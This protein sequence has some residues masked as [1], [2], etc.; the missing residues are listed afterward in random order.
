[1]ARTK[2]V[3]SLKQLANLKNF[4]K[5]FDRDTITSATVLTL[6]NEG[7]KIITAAYEDRKW[8]NRTYNL[9]N[10]YVAAV[11]GGG[12]VLGWTYLGPE[13][14]PDPKYERGAN[15]YH[16]TGREYKMSSIES[17]RTEAWN[18]VESY[19]RQHR[20]S[21]NITL[22]VGAAMFYA[23]ILE[24]KGY[25]VLSTVKNDMEN[26]ATKDL[27]IADFKL[28]NMYRDFLEDS[29]AR[30]LIGHEHIAFRK[31]ENVERESDRKKTF[32]TKV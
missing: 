11:V 21:E 9:Y 19:A 14:A 13:H 20:N 12:K 31:D 5:L 25:H 32:N 26:L 22:V 17:G 2:K 23:G 4:G 6:L 7:K 18:F 8:S 10:S 1:M 30:I 28:G 3:Q 29:N 27:N 15:K 16:N 24:S